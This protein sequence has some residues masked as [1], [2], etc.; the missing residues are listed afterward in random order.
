MGTFALSHIN[1]MA[2]S[3][4]KVSH[5]YCLCLFRQFL[6]FFLGQLSPIKQSMMI[7]AKIH[8]IIWRISPILRSWNYMANF[9]KP[10]KPTNKAFFILLFKS[11]CAFISLCPACS[12][13]SHRYTLAFRRAI[14]SVWPKFSIMLLEL[15]PTNKANIF[16]N[17]ALFMCQTKRL[18]FMIT[19]KRAKFAVVST[20]GIVG[21]YFTASKTG[22]L[23]N[24]HKLIITSF[25]GS[26][27]LH[28][29][30]VGGIT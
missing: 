4:S 24:Y 29:H 22:S 28:W 7:G 14:F 11:Y 19:L 21:K 8:N 9:N 18:P 3:L 26:N 10:I 30:I 5:I 17:C 2:I 20:S 1:M 23:F 13:Y 25:L 12:S 16:M 15:F 27:H 6:N